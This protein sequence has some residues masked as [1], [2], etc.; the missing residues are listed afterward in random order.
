MAATLRQRHAVVEL[1]APP[2]KE[3]LGETVV[4]LHA[5][6]H[7][8]AAWVARRIKAEVDAGTP[9]REC[10]VLV[11]A[12]S[13]FGDLH[14][15]LTAGGLPVEVVGLGGLLALPEVADVV[16]TLEVIDEPTANAALLRLLTG[17]RWRLGTR[18]LARLGQQARELLVVDGLAQQRDV[19]A[20]EDA[21]AGVDP[22]DVVALAD[23]LERPGHDGWSVDALQRVTALAAELRLL[24]SRATSRCSTWCTASSRSPASTSSWPRRRRRCRRGD[25]RRCRRSSTSSPA[26]PTSRA[27]ARCRRSWPTCAP[28]RSTSAASTP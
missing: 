4:A 1:T 28:P 6:W 27:R 7:D 5:S 3:D 13:D 18:D 10:A 25:A 8:E 16:A 21:V 11:R 2:G 23:A 9:A 26:S 24:R 14:A 22:C 20:L 19:D 15:A 12:R 17:P